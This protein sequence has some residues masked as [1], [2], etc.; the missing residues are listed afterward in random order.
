VFVAYNAMI[1]F[2]TKKDDHLHW[3]EGP[4]RVARR[5]HYDLL[6]MGLQHAATSVPT[7]FLHRQHSNLLW[8]LMLE[9]SLYK[10]PLWREKN[11][12]AINL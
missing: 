10:S 9:N 7:R 8:R 4:A 1:R 2:R 6:R 5:L 11:R 3:C 12:G